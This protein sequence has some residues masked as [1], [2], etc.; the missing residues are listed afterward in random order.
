[1]QDTPR[2]F[3]YGRF[4]EEFH[5]GGHIDILEAHSVCTVKGSQPR[6]REVTGVSGRGPQEIGVKTGVKPMSSHFFHP[7]IV[8]VEIPERILSGIR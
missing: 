6:G 8:S 2:V 7:S 3:N 5:I 4:S 1:M